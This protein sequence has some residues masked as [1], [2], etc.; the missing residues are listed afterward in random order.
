MTDTKYGQTFTVQRSNRE[1]SEPVVAEFYAIDIRHVFRYEIF[2][3][4]LFQF[5]ELKVETGQQVRVRTYQVTFLNSSH[6]V[7]LQN[8]DAQRR[9][10]FD[11]NSREF[12]QMVV[13]Q[14]QIVGVHTAVVVIVLHTGY[15]IVCKADRADDILRL[16]VEDIRHF[17]QLVVSTS[18]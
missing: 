18:E 8:Q 2:K 9:T 16:R 4:N 10:F 17:G 11:D 14:I 7:G 3:R 13:R 15:F 6:T 12:F 1:F 5:V